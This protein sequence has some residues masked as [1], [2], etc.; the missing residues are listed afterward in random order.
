MSKLKELK[1][2]REK[3]AKQMRDLHES[4][5]KEDRAFTVDDDA[6]WNGLD[7]DLQSL[8]A[9]IKR[10]EKIDGFV[11]PNP[12]ELR[13]AGKGQGG[14]QDPE[15]ENESSAFRSYLMNGMQGLND[16]QRSIMTK[17]MA[18]MNRKELRAFSAGTSNVGGATVP[19]SFLN[20]L[21][22][23]LKAY[24][25]MMQASDVMYTDTGATLPMP[26]FNYTNV[27]ATIVGEGAAGSLDASTP[28][29]SVNLGAYTYR[30][31]I[32]PVSYEFLQDSA[33]GEQFIVDA[34]AGSLARAVNAHAT[35]GT[36]TGQ[37]RGVVIDA[38]SGKVGTSGQTL[39]VISDDL[40]DL[41]H[42][43]DPAYRPTSEFMM[44]DTSLRV[45]RKIKDTAGRPIFLP[46]Y[47]GLSA[48]MPDTILGQKINI[49]QDVAV[50]A[51]NAKSILFGAFKKYKLRVVRDVTLLRLTERYADNLQVAFLLF[52]R[53]DGRLL[54]AGTNPVK[55]YQNSAT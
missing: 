39:S 19:Q 16:E 11:I 5:D 47:D 29:G 33:F 40:V 51:A 44:H 25:G 42:S 27:L 35:V 26:S 9:K 3:L 52:M 12:T 46:G 10:A 1:G 45:V 53:A 37:P 17:R 24:G 13:A 32:L 50:M 6:K 20:N 43:V 31:P 23:A 49:N 22:I 38:V 48:A 36:G 55:F 14:E 8:E 4:A 2:E 28:F 30:T 21:E 18:D 7:A 54:D 15:A 41:I 34:L